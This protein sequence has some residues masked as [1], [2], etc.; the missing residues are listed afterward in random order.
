MR[1][2]KKKSEDIK[3]TNFYESW[4]DLESDKKAVMICSGKSCPLSLVG[5]CKVSSSKI[6][7]QK[8]ELKM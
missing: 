8:A 6:V 4:G 1:R 5:V 7:L 2:A 3:E